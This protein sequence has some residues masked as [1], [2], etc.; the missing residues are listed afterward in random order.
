MSSRHAW[1]KGLKPIHGR[2]IHVEV[3]DSTMNFQKLFVPLDLQFS[4]LT[5]TH[6]EPETAHVWRF[7]RRDA[8]SNYEGSHDW[9]VECT[10]P[11]YTDEP[12][13]PADVVLL[14]KQRMSS[15]SLC[16]MPMK[17]LLAAVAKGIDGAKL[18]TMRRAALSE[19][20]VKEYRKTAAAIEKQHPWELFNAADYP[21][22]LCANNENEV[23]HEPL[24]L[25]FIFNHRIARRPESTASQ[26]FGHDFA[27]D[28]PRVVHLTK[29][30]PKETRKRLTGKSAKP[31]AWEGAIVV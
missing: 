1:E 31:Q 29:L 27:L 22:Q 9:T 19:R 25:N 20:E 4:G 18:D 8:L 6:R 30:P 5:A 14:L 7:C 15:S 21:R 13:R 16:Q 11:R 12:A 23:Q 3:I 24:Q 26:L 2:E 28:P 10:H 17:I